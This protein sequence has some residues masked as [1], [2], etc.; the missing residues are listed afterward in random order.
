MEKFQAAMLLG[1]VGDALGHGHA[2]GEDSASGPKVQKELGE[3]GGLDHLVLSPEKWPVSDNTIMHMTT[4]GALVTDFWCLDDLYREMVRRYVDVLEKLPGQRVDPATIEGCSQLKPDNYLL[5]WHTPFNE[6]GF[7]GSLCTALFASYA[8][9]GKRLEQWGRDMLRT[10]PLA[11][12]YCK[13]TIRHLAEYQEHWFYFE[14][15]WQFYLEERKISEDTENEASFPDR[16]N[17]EERDKTYRKWSSEGRGGRRGH[18]A[19]MIAYDALLG[20]KGSWTEL[21]HRAMFHGGESG[22]TGAIA[23]CLFGLLHGL[24]AVPAGLYRELEHGE[25]LRHLGEALY[26]LSTEENPKSSRICS[27]KTPIDVQALKKKVSRVTCDP[28]ARAILSS[29]LVYITDREDGPRELPPARRAEGGVSKTSRAPEPQ[30]AQ[31]RP[32]RFQLLKAKFMGTGREPCLKRTREVGRLIFK[33]RQ[34]PGRSLVTATVHKLLE[35]AREGAGRPA[36]GREPLGREKPRGLPAGR[37]SVKSIL[38][39]FL[40]AEE[41][42]AEEKPPAEPPRAAGGPLPKVGGRRSAALAK[43]RE[44]F[45]RSGCRCAEAG[46]LPLRADERKKRLPRSPLHRP[47]RR[48]LRTATL[49]STCIRAPPA[50]FLAVSAEPLLPFSIATVVC[51]PHSWMSH[52]ARV[53]RADL[54][55][56]P[57]GETG[58]APRARETPGGILA[59]GWGQP[60]Q[61]SAPRAT[62]P[63]DG[64]QTV[65]PGAGPQCVLRAAPS[66]ASPRGEVLPGR[67]P[68]MSPPGPDSQGGTGAAQG[69]RGARLGPRPGLVGGGPGAAPEV[70]LTVC[71]SEDETEGM[72]ADSEPEPLFAVQEN[73][74]EER[75]P[76]QIPPLAAHA[77]QAARRTQPA[78]EPPRLAARF[79]AA[80][81]VP[82]PPATLQ[83]ASGPEDQGW[84]LLGGEGVTGNTGAPPPTTAQGGSRGAPSSAGLSPAG[85]S[86][87]ALPQQG[88]GAQPTLAP[89]QRAACHG[90]DVPEAVPTTKP[91]KSS[92]GGKE[93]RRSPGTSHR[94]PKHQDMWG[95]DASQLSSK[96]PLLRGREERPA[97]DTGTSSHRSTASENRW[98]GLTGCAP[99]GR[100]A[101]VPRVPRRS[102]VSVS[103]R[104]EAPA[105]DGRRP[106]N[107]PSVDKSPPREQEGHRGPPSSPEPARPPLTAEG[108]ASRDPGENRV[109]SLNEQTQPRSVK[110]PGR[111]T[112]AGA[113]RSPP[114]RAPGDALSPGNRAA[115]EQEE[116]G[117]ARPTGPGLAAEKPDRQ[118]G[119]HSVCRASG[120]LPAPPREAAGAQTL[121]VE[122]H[123]AAPGELVT[124]ERK[125]AAGGR[126]SGAAWQSPR[127]GSLKPPTPAPD[128][129]VPQGSQVAGTPRRTLGTRP[130]PSENPQAKG[131]PCILPGAQLPGSAGPSRQPPPASTAADGPRAGRVAQKHPDLQ[132]PREVAGGERASLGGGKSHRGQEEGPPGAASLDGP[133]RK[134][135]GVWGEKARSSGAQEAVDGDPAA[136]TE[137][138]SQ[139]TGK[140]PEWPQRQRAGHTEGPPL[141]RGAP[142][143]KSPAPPPAGSPAHPAQ[144]Q[145]GRTAPPD[146]AQP[147]SRA[148]EVAPPAGKN[149][150]SRRP[151]ASRGGQGGRGEPRGQGESP[152]APG[153]R[154]AP[155]SAVPL[156]A[157]G[158]RGL[159]R[160]PTPGGPPDTP[161]AGRGTQGRG[162]GGRG[163]HLAKYRAQSFRDQRSFELS[164]RPA[165]LRANDTFAL[166]K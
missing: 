81:T 31:R 22:A 149:E 147:V 10:V 127:G 44:T 69:A 75:A 93:T 162:R 24:D 160:A 101:L 141:G 99:G 64:P 161:G 14:A 15:K 18:D 148:A 12:E 97:G 49:A 3:V 34:G 142:A 83:R 23:G 36:W 54:R 55:R 125:V 153:P 100:Q 60:R 28:A 131:G 65:V 59:P 139:H 87:P 116:R 144:A 140:S 73:C 79:P 157:L 50:R 113:S 46:L 118:P 138:P 61:P 26:R 68:V 110:A 152:T 133:G 19:P 134:G 8:V 45:E 52:G 43:L 164:F 37:S 98:E 25:T 145:A 126:I 102:G 119:G 95:E 9:Q 5:A 72:T 122:P 163:A 51:G 156:A 90:P 111:V 6:K 166:P 47:E 20:A 16:Y 82:P 27:N 4:A 35:K 39:V 165:I 128:V 86:P 77:A 107:L 29:L 143:A 63:R 21:C 66:P 150:A 62:T 57:R 132:A 78:V 58:T 40:A 96:T 114:A 112:A 32:T 38:K 91:Q 108:S 7:L 158:G 106:E 71:S 70:T 121:P 53:T 84:R 85:L 89:P 80:H 154:P 115:E 155:G 109:S 105:Q 159:A 103:M 11:E 123:M 129:P 30:D 67:E 146:S 2:F 94:L 117:A 120:S 13:R 42:E 74:P 135:E 33:D 17:A 130:P 92:P 137:A 48:V 104:P 1:A 88:P 124:G 56:A 136:P 151:V 76:G 41:K